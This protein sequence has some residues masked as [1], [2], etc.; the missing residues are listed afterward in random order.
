MHHSH[1]TNNEEYFIVEPNIKKHNVFKIK[2]YK[3]A[4]EQADIIVFLVAHDE[5]KTLQ[6]Q[7]D[8]V[9]LNFCGIKRENV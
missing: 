3:T 7:N 8:K 6:I 9:V 4:A 1:N 2:D 5:F